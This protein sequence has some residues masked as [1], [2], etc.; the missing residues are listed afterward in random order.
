MNIIFGKCCNFNIFGQANHFFLGDFFYCGLESS[1]DPQVY[2]YIFKPPFTHKDPQKKLLCVFWNQ[3]LIHVTKYF[4]AKM[5]HGQIR[6]HKTHHDPDL[7]EATTFPLIVDFVPFHK[8][9]IQM[10]FCFGTPKWES[11]NSQ[12]WDSRDFGAT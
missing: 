8:A 2:G 6:I 10:T 9:H 12:S 4:D 7:G 11:R 3:T 1:K 5:S